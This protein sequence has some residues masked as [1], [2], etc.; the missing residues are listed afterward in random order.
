MASAHVRSDNA[1]WMIHRLGKSAC[2]HMRPTIKMSDRI[3]P[4][5]WVRVCSVWE[6]GDGSKSS[7]QSMYERTKRSTMPETPE[8]PRKMRKMAGW[9]IRELD[10]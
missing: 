4:T 2:R 8:T 5:D 10:M 9:V 6:N 1:A 7:A 3:M